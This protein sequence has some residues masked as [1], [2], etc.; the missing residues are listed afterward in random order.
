[1]SK[2]KIRKPK[3]IVWN[4]KLNCCNSVNKPERCSL[5]HDVTKLNKLSDSGANENCSQED[6]DADFDVYLTDCSQNG[7]FVNGELVGKWKVS[8]FGLS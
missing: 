8:K 5:C 4:D 7:T 3:N 1:M 2:G 6:D